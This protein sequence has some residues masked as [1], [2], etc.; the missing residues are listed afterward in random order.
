MNN[1][2]FLLLLIFIIV[3]IYKNYDNI[4]IWLLN[5]IIFNRGILTPNR[6]WYKISDLFLSDGSGIDLYNSYKKKYGDFGLSTM[7][8]RSIYL[9]TNV[10][11]IKIIVDNSP[12]LFQVG[13]IKE[14]FFNEFMP[15]NVGV[16]T[17]CPW[18]RRRHM[19]EVA[20]DTDQL[21]K[22]SQKYNQD[23]Y[24]TLLNWKDK[25][26]F[27]Y[28]DFLKVSQKMVAKIIF[29]EDKIH[30]DI[31]IYLSEVNTTEV[32]TNPNFGVKK[33]IENNFIQTINYHIENP[34]SESLIQSCLDISNNNEE[35]FNQIPHFIFPIGGLF[36]TTIPRLLI[37][38]FNH[39]HVFHK[40]IQEV[41]S[42]SNN[43]KNIYHMKYLRKC[44]METLRLINPL[45]TT[46]RT[47][48]E[49]FSFD[50]KYSFKKGT[51]FLILN[52]PVLREKEYFENPNKFIPERWTEEM[53]Q[54][55]YAISFNQGPQRCPAKELVIFLCQSF[56]YN[57]FTIKNI[58]KD[59]KVQINQIDIE[60]IPQI[61]NP[62][63]IYLKFT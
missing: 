53:E 5:R 61:T 10:K 13:K 55:Y 6:F 2:Y 8:G 24:K 33:S 40:V 37:M 48:S 44:I 62:F 11:Y 27:R 12:N 54:S 35:I 3:I 15:K 30:D 47:L 9:V 19:N 43:S 52:N 28:D 57:F 21:H 59:T 26:E 36:I 22:Y 60:D 31:F 20:L 39:K 58:D 29:N 46:F 7:F 56:V 16:S 1:K 63:N 23:M 51:Q 4:K 14:K 34:N 50:E 49:N 32:F 45:I 18:K 38:I 42:T 41:N 17:G 25:S